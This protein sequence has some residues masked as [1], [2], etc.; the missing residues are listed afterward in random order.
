M[1][2]KLLLIG[3]IIFEALGIV[4]MKE[5]HGLTVWWAVVMMA[6][7]FLISFVCFTYCLRKME[8]AVTYAIWSASGAVIIFLIGLFFYKEVI[9]I[10]IAICLA[11]IVL[12]VL[13]LG[14]R[15]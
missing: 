10:P 15:S 6:V 12:G 9:T 14:S 7:F 2:E 5:A 8:V 4:M 3:A 1:Q 11:L 13:V